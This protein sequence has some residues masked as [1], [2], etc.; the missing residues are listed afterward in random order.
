[1]T[2]TMPELEKNNTAERTLINP[3][4]DDSF[5]INSFKCRLSIRIKQ[6]TLIMHSVIVIF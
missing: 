5:I 1:M 2:D 6:P 4:E 3:E